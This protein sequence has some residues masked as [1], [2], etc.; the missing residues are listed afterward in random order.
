MKRNVRWLYVILG[1]IIF[2][3]LGTVYSWSIFRK[4]LEN[5]LGLSSTQSGLPFMVFL[6]FYAFLMPFGGKLQYKLKP[7]KVLWIGGILTALGWISSSYVNNI[8]QLIFTYGV[9]AGSGVGIAYGVPI[10]VVTRWFPDKRGLALGML[11][12]GFGLSPFITA[13]IAKTLIDLYGPFITFRIMGNIFLILILSLSMPFKFPENVIQIGAVDDN[14]ITTKEMLKDI[15]FYALWVCFAISTLVG[16]MIIG[17]TSPIGEE[18]IKI[19]TK[20]VALLVSFF[21]I[22]NGIGRPIFGFLTDKIKPIF[23]I[24]TSYV[25]ILIAAIM[26]I[27]Y[28][29]N[30]II[31]YTISLSLFWMNFGGWLAIAPSLTSKFFG[32]K[33]YSQNYGMLFT[34]YGIGAITGNLLSGISKDFF[35]SYKLVAYP[36]ITL[37]V[38]GIIISNIFFIDKNEKQVIK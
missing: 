18:I 36:I 19:D 5:M 8:Y 1:I 11:L 17:I 4:P 13:P 23:A 3:C 26:M 10:S 21:S 37:S 14:A 33:Y 34:A 7:N 29:E 2:I 38:L 24:N 32:N 25:L 31:L 28:S 30:S 27:F 35:G 9:I 16:L 15:R 20:K 12:T 22:F 6:A